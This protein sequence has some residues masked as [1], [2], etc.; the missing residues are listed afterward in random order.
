[1]QRI[2]RKSV[3]QLL[4]KSGLFRQSK[5]LIRIALVILLSTALVSCDGSSDSANGPSSGPTNGPTPQED[6]NID[7]IPLSELMGASFN[8]TRV[9]IVAGESS[10]LSWSIPAAE[11]V[12][13]LPISESVE[14]TGELTVSPVQNMQYL[15]LAQVDGSEKPY[16]KIIAIS[17]REVAGVTLQA[18]VITGFAPLSVVFTPS[19]S[20][21]TN[22]S[23]YYWD[24]EGDGGPEDGGLGIGASGFDTLEVRTGSFIL[25]EYDTIGRPLTYVFEKAGSYT[26]RIRVWDDDGNQADAQVTIEVEN[27]PPAI[28]ELYVSS[29]TAAGQVPLDV[30]FEVSA[31]DADGVELVEWDLD[32]D[33]SYDITSEVVLSREV[34]T[35]TLPT[36]YETPGV[37]APSVRVTD[38][39]GLSSV[40]SAPSIQVEASANPI[41]MV[42]SLGSLSGEAPF[43]AFLSVGVVD[44]GDSG[45]ALVRMD[46]D[47]DGTFDE[48]VE[49]TS[50]S[51]TIQVQ[52]LYESAGVF[53]I[54]IEAVAV[55]GSIGK[56][57]VEVI[58]DADHTLSVSKNTADPLAGELATVDIE[59]GGA[60]VSE[61][62][63]VDEGGQPVKAIGVQQRRV[64]GEHTFT[65]DGRNQVGEVARP[66][67]Y[68][69]LLNYKAG[70]ADHVLDLRD[71]HIVANYYPAISVP[72]AELQAGAQPFANR[73]IVY[74]YTLD[75]YGINRLTAYITNRGRDVLT[76]AASIFRARHVADGDYTLEWL[77]DGTTGKL[78]PVVVDF[79]DQYVPG[80]IAESVAANAILLTHET[81][82]ED[83]KLDKPIFHPSLTAN[84]SGSSI[85][86]TLSNTSTIQLSVSDT[87]SGAEV[88]RQTFT[89]VPAGNASVIWDGRDNA[90][91]L[92]APVG[93]RLQLLAFG[94]Y[95]D[96]SLP[97]AVMQRI[98]Y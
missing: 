63:I 85:D 36:V 77:G 97:V 25:T 64:L 96:T 3:K 94:P 88:R 13:L 4:G 2:M 47:G 41:P 68:Y 30:T 59:L 82:I 58:V 62:L 84:G 15:L 35:S 53:Y 42:S 23:R 70:D 74:P 61:V 55:D 83:I 40:S 56:R 28:D 46:Y 22:I 17:V 44:S 57:Y 18:N 51:Q 38:S 27:A 95:G 87:D 7:F 14:L 73:P 33:G 81:T 72:S 9:S 39:D 32:G 80:V 92:L 76:S 60:T 78:L 10:V 43:Q 19:V 79:V 37:F 8:A 49:L 54:Y 90:G 24:F 6:F 89:N 66:G 16:G 52:H 20:S 86:F 34:Y 75:R 71:T 31:T 98:R 5:R 26:T 45:L 11:S 21:I 48:V 29:S 91:N 12:Q 1:M 65:W 50:S 67:I 93:Y 69:A